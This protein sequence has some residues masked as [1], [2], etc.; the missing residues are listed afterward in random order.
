MT[1]ENAI[2]KIVESILLEQED[3]SNEM[4]LL[5]IKYLSL[6]YSVG[7]DEG[8]RKV[9]HWKP[10]QQIMEGQVIKTWPSAT[11]AAKAMGVYANT[12][13]HAANGTLKTCK[14]FKWKYV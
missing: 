6:M 8:R 12:I 14:G 2:E 13:A 1:Q 11:D 4:L 3:I 5:I 9:G 7:F 10:V